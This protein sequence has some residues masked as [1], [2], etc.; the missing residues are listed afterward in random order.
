MGPASLPHPTQHPQVP[1][2]ALPLGS[3]LEHTPPLGL[4][5]CKNEW[6]PHLK[7]SF[8]GR[9]TH[10]AQVSTHQV[11]FLGHQLPGRQV[12]EG[13][14]FSTTGG[15]WLRPISGSAGPRALL[16]LLLSSEYNCPPPA[17]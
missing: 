3:P 2:L 6:A 4:R 11:A 16:R 12:P 13:W 7:S 14:A 9:C 17:S 8:E 5:V 10:R 1:T 15:K